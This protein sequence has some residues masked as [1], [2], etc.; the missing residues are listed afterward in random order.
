MA[1]IRGLPVLNC[2]L[3]Y[4]GFAVKVLIFKQLLIRGNN[5]L[6]TKTQ[7]QVQVGG[8]VVQCS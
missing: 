3:P 2:W 4:G 8:F 6:Y 1:I 5:Y 7:R